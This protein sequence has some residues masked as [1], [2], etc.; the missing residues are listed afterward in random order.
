MRLNK[1]VILNDALIDCWKECLQWS[2]FEKKR[3][4]VDQFNKTSKYIKQGIAMGA[5]RMGLT[6]PGPY[7]QAAALVQIF[8]DGTVAVSI[9]GIEMG[10][11]LNTK[12]LQVAS[13][14]LGIPISLIT[15]IDAST[16]KTCNTP[17]TGGSQGADIHGRAI[18]MCCEK[19]MAGLRPI[20]KEEPD[21]EKAVMIA[22]HMRLPL[23]ASE[24]MRIDREKHG[25]ALD[26]STYH[27]SGAA[28]VVSQID[29]RT[30]EQQVREH[31]ML[32]FYPFFISHSCVY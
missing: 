11:G 31:F 30:G 7:E 32:L 28:C 18:Q 27:T 22:Y 14:A 19:L 26:S 25:I 10:Q 17:E 9:G 3:N 6:H 15:I 8:M 1:E 2:E 20:L 12:C 4:E 29:Y 21:W 23:Q 5:T 24:H 13:R 16:D